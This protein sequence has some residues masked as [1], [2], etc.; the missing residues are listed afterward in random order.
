MTYRY[1]YV[2]LNFK[3]TKDDV[4]TL[5]KW[6]PEARHHLGIIQVCDAS[7][8]DNSSVVSSNHKLESFV[9]LYFYYF[10]ALYTFL[11]PC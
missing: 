4:S 5:I 1:F 11:S 8:A 3:Q 10:L 9:F 7:M 6:F 2:L